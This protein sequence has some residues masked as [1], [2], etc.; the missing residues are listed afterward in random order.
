MFLLRAY[1][2]NTPASAVLINKETER[3]PNHQD[4]IATAVYSTHSLSL[5]LVLTLAALLG[6]RSH[7]WT[8]GSHQAS[9]QTRES[10]VPQHFSGADRAAPSDADAALV[11]RQVVAAYHSMSTY[12]DIG[13]AVV[14]LGSTEYRVDFETLFKRPGK[15][16]F[17]WTVAYSRLPGKKQTGLVWSDGATAWASYSFR[18]NKPQQKK[19]LEFAVAGATAASW[20][21]AHTIPSLLSDQVGG[22]RLDEMEGLRIAGED[23]ADGVAS[24]VLVGYMRDGEE[25]KLW[26]GKHD[27]LIRRIEE[28]SKTGT[29]EEVRRQI[30]LDQDIAD[31]RFSEHGR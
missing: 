29:R 25:R 2:F 7:L 6:S 26:V 20:M 5:V 4:R 12:A 16:R 28:R 13:T 1:I 27:H 21:T 11:M 18:G 24:V 19:D 3:G 14:H 22:I 23:I 31:S 9:A 15:L 30:V 10:F 8:G 17:A